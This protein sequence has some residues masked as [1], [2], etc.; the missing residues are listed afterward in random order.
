MQT[1]SQRTAAE[2]LRGWPRF[3]FCCF[4][5]IC[6]FRWF[7]IERYGAPIA[8]GDDLDGIA[9]RILARI[10][11]G[12]F[13]WSLLF[14]A[15]NGDHVITATRLF[16]ILWFKINGEWD[17]KLVMI[18]KTPIYAAA[19]TIFV[20][21]LTRGLDRGRFAAAAVL[22]ALFAFPFNYHNLLWAFQ[23]QFDFF[24]LTAALGWLAV[25]HGR[26]GW[27]LTCAAVSPFTLG[28]GPILAASFVP[29][30]LLA[31]VGL[32]T[33]TLRRA[34]VLSAV[35]IVIAAIGASFRTPD[36]LQ[37][38]GTAFDKAATL[39][40]LYGWPFTNLLSAVERLPGDAHLIP[41]KILNF[42]SA[43][44]SWMLWFAE[45]LHRFPWL[46]VAVHVVFALFVMSPL[47]VVAWW[48]WRK[49]LALSQVL[50][51]AGVTVFAA[52]MLAATAVARTEQPTI[53]MRFLDHV[54]LAG[55][56]SIVGAFMLVARSRRWLPFV[57]LWAAGMGVGYVATMGATMSQVVNRKKPQVSL[58]LLQRYYAK[59]EVNG[60]QRNNHQALLENRAFGLF[61]VGA[62]P[63]EFFGMLDDPAL[64][65][66]LPRAI[67]APELGRGA[68][69]VAADAMAR[70]GLVL[71]F[72]A[73]CAAAWVAYRS[74][75]VRPVPTPAVVPAAPA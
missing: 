19:M 27:A 10:Q 4:L 62:D 65:P 54:I 70:K 13:E 28:A 20:H 3:L 16:E 5:I 44:S 14:A 36:A 33:I 37:S 68:V 39:V 71:V 2:G 74:R 21:L 29:F 51:L 9:H 42:P 67:T 49:E 18:V 38:G 58:E 56:T 59:N 1:P 15:H 64:R 60:V 47:L 50:G 41:G 72:G 30:F 61:I 43:E 66:V 53:A 8:W 25:L 24:F 34:L 52:L 26:H 12:T 31:A 55:F 40:K 7:L 48:L 63:T 23:S 73:A 11:N 17:P 75:R 46:I 22:T 6:G 69:A 57:A 35:A 45:Q 32:K